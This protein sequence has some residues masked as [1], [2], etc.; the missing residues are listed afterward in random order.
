[1]ALAHIFDATLATSSL[2]H[3]PDATLPT[4]SRA[5]AHIPDATLPTSSLALAHIPDATLP[6]SSLALAHL[7]LR[8]RWVGVGWANNVQWHTCVMLRYQS[9]LLHLH[10]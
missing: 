1:M 10:T 9:L 7:M 3:I 8:Y 5:L 4:S 6:T 2:A